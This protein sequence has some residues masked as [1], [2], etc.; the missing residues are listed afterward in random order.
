MT[1]RAN[2][3][4][5]YSFSQIPVIALRRLP[6]SKFSGKCKSLLKVVKA[7]ECKMSGHKGD[8]M[9]LRTRMKS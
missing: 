9:S 2:E 4:H 1:V 6:M 3:N 8:T 5:C 7:E